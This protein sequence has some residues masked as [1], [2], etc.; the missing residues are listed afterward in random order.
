M[1]PSR[2]LP[3]QA[4]GCDFRARVRPDAQAALHELG[5]FHDDID[6]MRQQQPRADPV[7]TGQ[8]LAEL[9]K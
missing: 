5:D 9:R 1:D 4:A 2:E 3:A 7:M 8:T 6:E